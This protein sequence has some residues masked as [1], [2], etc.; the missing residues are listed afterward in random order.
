MEPSSSVEL[1][2]EIDPNRQ[3]TTEALLAEVSKEKRQPIQSL[4]TGIA[5]ATTVYAEPLAVRILPAH[6][7][8][9]VPAISTIDSDSSVGPIDAF[10]D[11]SSNPSPT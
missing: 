9:T 7:N 10:S 8:Q 4:K 2:P 1:L 5:L 11:G 6:S 3:L